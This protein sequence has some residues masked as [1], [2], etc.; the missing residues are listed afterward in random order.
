MKAQ[1]RI[2]AT[3]GKCKIVQS[4]SLEHIKSANRRPDKWAKFKVMRTGTNIPSFVCP[5]IMREEEKTQS[6]PSF[7]TERKHR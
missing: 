2:N 6:T 5:S 1:C 3:K 7:R 4:A